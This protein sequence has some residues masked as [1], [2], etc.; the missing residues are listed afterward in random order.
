M[1]LKPLNEENIHQ[2]FL[3]SSSFSLF[4]LS[5]FPLVYA[6]ANVLMRC[7]VTMVSNV[8]DSSDAWPGMLLHAHMLQHSL[9]PHRPG[10]TVHIHTH[11]HMHTHAC[12][13]AL[14]NVCPFREGVHAYLC[15]CTQRVRVQECKVVYV[16]TK[17]LQLP[18]WEEKLPVASLQT[19]AG[20]PRYQP[21]SYVEADCRKLAWLPLGE[22]LRNI[23]RQ[24][25]KFIWG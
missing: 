11:M 19:A 15:A 1:F 9:M 2:R 18:A 3:S 12:T 21:I 8:S 24:H 16:R 14:W 13:N 17:Q 5:S 25:D 6:F 22:K 10:H 20:Q 4:P 7:V 23:V